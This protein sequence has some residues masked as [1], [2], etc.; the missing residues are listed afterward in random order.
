MTVVNPEGV[1]DV[2]REW[3]N[4]SRGSPMYAQR[5]SR[6]TTRS[7]GGEGRR[8]SSR[9]R[10]RKSRVMTQRLPRVTLGAMGADQRPVRAL[11]KWIG[12]HRG[13]ARLD[14]APVPPRRGQPVAERPQGMQPQ[15]A[16]ALALDQ[17]PAPVG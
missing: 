15:V 1:T 4:G 6:A 16:N 3:L 7:G 13:E 9:R 8:P 10:S 12:P 2:V 11:T 17:H 5:G 14:R